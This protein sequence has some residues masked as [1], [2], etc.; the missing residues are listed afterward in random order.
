MKKWMLVLFVALFVLPCSREADAAGRKKKGKNAATAKVTE[1][2][3]A[4]DKR[5][6][7]RIYAESDF[8]KSKNTKSDTKERER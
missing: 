6:I 3:S 2:K 1:K 7:C 5:R 4:Y 8:V